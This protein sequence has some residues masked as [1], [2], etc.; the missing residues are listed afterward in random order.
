[1]KASEKQRI[2]AVMSSLTS[3]NMRLD[4]ELRRCARLLAQKENEEEE[5]DDDSV[6]D[7]GEEWKRNRM[8]YNDC[9]TVF[10][11]WFCCSCS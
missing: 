4:L 9:W 2:R 7:D 8:V 5:E 3:E 11:C 1:M 6:N 10:F